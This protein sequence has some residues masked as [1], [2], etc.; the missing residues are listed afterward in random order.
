MAT[1]SSMAKPEVT[2]AS[3]IIKVFTK[4]LPSSQGSEAKRRI[5]NECH[6]PHSINSNQLTNSSYLTE[7][8]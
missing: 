1:A 5:S 2:R 7:E 4:D 6:E 8:C 3:I